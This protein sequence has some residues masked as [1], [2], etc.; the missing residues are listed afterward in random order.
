MKES[1]LD[2]L[3]EDKRRLDFLES[4]AC[5]R[6]WVAGYAKAGRGYRLRNTSRPAEKGARP[7]VREAIDAAMRDED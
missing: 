4:R 2:R 6:L 3:R 5:G 1:E 7:S